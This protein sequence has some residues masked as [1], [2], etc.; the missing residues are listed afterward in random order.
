MEILEPGSAP[1]SD[2][3]A[4]RRERGTPEPLFREDIT[5][6]RR[7]APRTETV[8]ADAAGELTYERRL[9]PWSVVLVRQDGGGPTSPYE[10]P[11][12]P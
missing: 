9:A 7:T 10:N 4:A 11:A 2:T 12:T 1:G 8:R 3:L 5:A 6:L